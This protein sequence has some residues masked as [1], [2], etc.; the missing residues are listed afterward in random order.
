VSP[1]SQR[2]DGAAPDFGDQ[3][4]F[5]GAGPCFRPLEVGRSAATC[6]HCGVDRALV[7]VQAL[8]DSGN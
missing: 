4:G 1:G 2:R 8:K 7:P 3:S 5:T 6:Q